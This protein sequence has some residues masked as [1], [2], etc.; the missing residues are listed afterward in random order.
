MPCHAQESLW[1]VLKGGCKTLAGTRL[2]RS[3]LIQPSNDL[4]TINMRQDCVVE[5]LQREE[6]LVDVQRIL[7]QLADCDRVLKHFM[8]RPTDAAAG[9]RTCRAEASIAS[10]LHLKQ[11]VQVAPTLAAALS[12]NGECPP[13]NDLLRA[14]ERIMLSPDLVEIAEMIDM[15]IEGQLACSPPGGML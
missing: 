3:S 9:S 5:L 15:H 2:L 11:L 1:G 6:M 8:Q 12:S 4:S 10:V 14:V 13:E 7:P